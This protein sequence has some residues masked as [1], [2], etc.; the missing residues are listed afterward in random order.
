MTSEHSVTNPHGKGQIKLGFLSESVA[1]DL[2]IVRSSLA[3]SACGTL[4]LFESA[5]S[6]MLI[7]SSGRDVA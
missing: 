5:R 1:V 6:L 7:N 2:V 3:F 4:G